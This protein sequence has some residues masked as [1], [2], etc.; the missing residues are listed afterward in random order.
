MSLQSC[1]SAAALMLLTIFPAHSVAQTPSLA[2]DV[3][4]ITIALSI[5]TSS[6]KLE[7]S[8][9]PAIITLTNSGKTPAYLTTF[10]SG[11]DFLI[12]SLQ[13][14]LTLDGNAVPKAGLNERFDHADGSIERIRIDPGSV[15]HLSIDIKKLFKISQPG[16]YLFSVSMSANSDAKVEI[17]TQPLQ[18][19]LV[20]SQQ[21]TQ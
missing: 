10:R 17:H 1:L 16:S 8:S 21:P 19:D 4:P 14:H 5:P 3:S 20:A 7:Q 9:L 11:G 12:T 15:K 18:I 13:F 6:A 2:T